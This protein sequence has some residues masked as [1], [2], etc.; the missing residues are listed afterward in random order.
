MEIIDIVDQPD[1]GVMLEIEL[2]KEERDA[3][4]EFGLIE[5]FKRLVGIDTK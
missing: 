4:I 3:L 5:A 1:G 2:T